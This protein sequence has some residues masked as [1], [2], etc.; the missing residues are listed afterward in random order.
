MKRK[1][2]CENFLEKTTDYLLW[3][4]GV[5]MLGIMF[6]FLAYD[7]VISEAQYEMKVK[8]EKFLAVKGKK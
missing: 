5:I 6:L 2:N 4:S 7:R 3:M 8:Y 1:N